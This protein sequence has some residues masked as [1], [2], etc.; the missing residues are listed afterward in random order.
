MNILVKVKN[1]GKYFKIVSAPR[2]D[3]EGAS[4]VR[5]CLWAGEA[6]GGKRPHRFGTGRGRRSPGSSRRW[7][8]CSC[9]NEYNGYQR[10]NE[11]M[12]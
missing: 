3:S 4:A 12:K 8:L 10:I 2:R 6:G 11:N 9:K 1:D 7:L 5:P